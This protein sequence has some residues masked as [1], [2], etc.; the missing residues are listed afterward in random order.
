MV[1]DSLLPFNHLA[2]SRA[3][4]LNILTSRQADFKNEVESGKA[5]RLGLYFDT[6]V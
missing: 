5:S 4:S 1:F 3:C 2:I 6:C